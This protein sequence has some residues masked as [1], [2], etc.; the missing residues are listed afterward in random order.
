MLTTVVV[1]TGSIGSRHLNV[2]R[3]I[4]GMRALALPLRPGRRNEL[5]KEGFESVVDL[6]EAR[7]LGARA[8]L[9]ATDS[10]RHQGDAVAALKLGF[11]VLVEKPITADARQAKKILQAAR[12]NRKKVFV[13]CVLR[14]S[15]SLNLFRTRLPKIGKVHAVR[16]EC[17]S[18]LP[19]WR[20]SR[21]YRKSYAARPEEGGVLRDLIHEI[22]Y[23]G[24]LYGWPKSVNARLTNS[25]RLGIKAEEAA[26]LFWRTEKGATV[27]IRL[28][29]L[30]KPTVRRMAAFGEKG[31]LDWNGVAETVSFAGS[32][33]EKPWTIA[34][35]QP[36]NDKFAAQFLAFAAALKGKS[37][38]LA[39]GIDGFRSIALCDA[40]RRSSK[41]GREE[42]VHY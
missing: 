19:D 42:R 10:G 39:T 22:D 3:R 40:A 4:K 32:A 23:A 34:R 18:Y 6:A 7:A 28:D 35:P 2:I 36:V 20:P 1:G 14:F 5:A 17:Q 8:A 24:W 25:G 29:Y 30:T 12:D 37:S 21:D 41:S 26:D 13:G 16:I 11:H 33:R 15:D 9:I 38:T 31:S 27:S